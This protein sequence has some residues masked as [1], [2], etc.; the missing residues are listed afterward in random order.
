MRNFIQHDFPQLIREDGES[1]TYL[2]PHGKRYP[3]VTSI[4]GLESKEGIAKWRQR[5]GPEAAARILKQSSARGTR[6]HNLCECYLKEQELQI[7]MFD[8]EIFTSL[9]PHLD[10]IDNIHCIETPLHS[11]F[12]EVAGTVDCI[13]EYEGKLCV[14]DFKTSAKLKQH[15]Y[16]GNYFMQAAAY[17]VMFE[18]LTEIPVNKLLIL[19]AV[20]D[21]Q[22]QIFVEKRDTWIPKFIELRKEYRRLKNI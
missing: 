13:G 3:S 19:I 4:T 14:I 16:I 15:R 22:P 18:E 17:A 5:V 21:E 8:K 7:D 10:K 1:R 9:K 6:I 20:D 11:H 12:M 2:T